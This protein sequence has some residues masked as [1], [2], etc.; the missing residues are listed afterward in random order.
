V[1]SARQIVE[2]LS[3]SKEVQE[4]VKPA[5]KQP[6]WCTVAL[7]AVDFA[8]T[9]V[10]QVAQRSGLTIS[11]VCAMLIKMELAGLVRSCAGGYLRLR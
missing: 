2:H 5:G 6:F 4:S 11:E 10:N 3:L 8:P 1:E 9:S 7:D